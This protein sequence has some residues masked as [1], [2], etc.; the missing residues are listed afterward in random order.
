MEYKTLT[1]EVCGEEFR[2]HRDK[3]YTAVEVTGIL[4]PNLY[5]DAIDCPHCG[6]HH[7]RDVNA[8]RNLRF[9]GLWLYGFV[10]STSTARYAANAC[11]NGEC[12][13]EGNG[14]E[15]CP[16]DLRLQFF[17]TQEQCKSLKQELNSM[18]YLT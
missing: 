3:R 5:H 6:C 17:E 15:P 4:V 11:P 18:N 1:C 9:Y 10:Q 16:R 14:S 8:A 7:D 12:R 13:R 2:P